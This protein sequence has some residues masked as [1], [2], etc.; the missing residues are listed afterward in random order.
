[1]SLP[2]P[3][4]SILVTML[5]PATFL[6]GCYGHSL[7]APVAIGLLAQLVSERIVE[8]SVQSRL[9]SIDCS[10]QDALSQS[11][12]LLRSELERKQASLQ[13][14]IPFSF[15]AMAI[16]QI[17]VWTNPCQQW[18]LYSPSGLVLGVDYA[19]QC[20]FNALDNIQDEVSPLGQVAFTD[21]L[22][23]SVGS[24][25]AV[26]FLV[27]ANKAYQVKVISILAGT[28]AAKTDDTL[29][30]KFYGSTA[31]LLSIL[32]AVFGAAVG[33]STRI[34]GII[35][36]AFC[37]T[38]YSYE[39]ITIKGTSAPLWLV[40]GAEAGALHYLQ[41]CCLVAIGVYPVGWLPRELM[42]YLV[43]YRLKIKQHASNLNL[44]RS[45]Q[46]ELA[47]VK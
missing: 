39:K 34:V 6:A 4:S 18:Q 26:S 8:R 1:M 45:R 2:I 7:V 32:L 14:A 44:V 38:S 37:L 11:E 42:S 15:L 21:L 3:F 25:A 27:N 20:F 46:K 16:G 5:S 22:V 36:G 10:R 23:L 33:P 17:T 41:L 9:A 35:V 28:V 13:Q 30:W 31:L 43:Y 29:P 24:I 47:K 40:K 19:F 12:V